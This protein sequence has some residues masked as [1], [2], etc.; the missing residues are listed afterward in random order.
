LGESRGR[1][2]LF[3]G[4]SQSLAIQNAAPLKSGPRLQGDDIVGAHSHTR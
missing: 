3:H 4:E 2:D 1:A